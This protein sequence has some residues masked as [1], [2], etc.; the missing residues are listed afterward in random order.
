ME[1]EYLTY[2]LDREDIGLDG[3][4]PLFFHSLSEYTYKGGV[5]G[6]FCF[7]FICI[8]S[9]WLHTKVSYYLNII[10]FFYQLNGPCMEPSAYNRI[11]TEITI[12]VSSTS[13]TSTTLC[14]ALSSSSPARQHPRH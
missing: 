14:L 9:S 2:R 11:T 6:D 1:E 10:H 7:C 12:R 5:V 13:V 3:Y 4:E 8:L